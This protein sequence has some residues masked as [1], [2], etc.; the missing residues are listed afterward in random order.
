MIPSWIL[1]CL[2]SFLFWN[3]HR[4]FG[5]GMELQG[6]I[7]EIDSRLNFY[8]LFVLFSFCSDTLLINFRH[9]NFRVLLAKVGSYL[10]LLFTIN[11]KT[12]I[13]LSYIWSETIHS[14][15]LSQLFIDLN[16]Y[17][18]NLFVSQ[19]THRRVQRKSLFLYRAGKWQPN[20]L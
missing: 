3:C 20:Y 8:K 2:F 18:G 11:K 19:T 7:K 6:L 16:C 5:V 14:T 12:T 10:S 1:H 15:L 9:C 13:I 4:W 17:I